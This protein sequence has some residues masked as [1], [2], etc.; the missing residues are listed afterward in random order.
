MAWRDPNIVP[1]SDFFDPKIKLNYLARL[2]A[3]K[4]DSV[5]KAF[6]TQ[7][8]EWFTQLK[9]KWDH[10]RRVLPYLITGLFD[11]NEEIQVITRDFLALRGE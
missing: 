4:K 8:G 1:L 5:R 2:S 7:L 3:D 11:T 10:D 6:I 9:D